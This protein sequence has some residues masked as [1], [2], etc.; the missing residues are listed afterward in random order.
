MVLRLSVEGLEEEVRAFVK[1]FSLLPQHRNMATSVPYEEAKGEVQILFHFRHIPLQEI[2]EPVSV[3]FK[4]SDGKDLFFTL[5]TG[6]VIRIGDTIS[7]TG[8]AAAG[9]L[10]E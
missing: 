2:N 6:N 10:K 8:R 7:I 4:T 9:L 3:W 5:L 1:D